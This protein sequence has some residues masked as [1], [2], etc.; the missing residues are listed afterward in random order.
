M[1]TTQQLA[2]YL[3]TG[4][5]NGS[6]YALVALGFVTIFTV[7]EV[8]NFAQGEFV[9]LGPMT[10]I[11]WGTEPHSLRPFSVGP[12]L[13]LAGAVIRLQSLWVLATTAVTLVGLYLFF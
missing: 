8:I 6:I 3:V 9:M 5:T 2:Q 4:V 1:P 7:T 13:T 12:A 10:L 11:A